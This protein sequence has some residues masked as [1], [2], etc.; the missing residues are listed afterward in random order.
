[1]RPYLVCLV[2]TL[3]A[4]L[5]CSAAA[6]NAA[7]TVQQNK[8]DSLLITE[9]PQV[10]EQW[11]LHCTINETPSIASQCWADAAAALTQ[12]TDR[13]RE[14]EVIQKVEELQA[15][16][17]ERAAQLQL[18]EVTPPETSIVSQRALLKSTALVRTSPLLRKAP[19]IAAK[20]A[21]PK[22]P[23]QTQAAS[24]KIRN[25]NPTKTTGTQKNK[26]AKKQPS[27]DV[28]NTAQS[29]KIKITAAAEQRA[30][31]HS[32]KERIRES[33]KGTTETPK[34]RKRLWRMPD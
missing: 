2:I 32:D 15:T 4:S 27:P 10:V 7:S 22:R 1:M 19:S 8:S 13:I 16:W 5:C 18:A 25:P 26:V 17:L 14:N 30:A 21:K 20:Q 33:E 12:Y 3:A 24:R 11:T 29:K 34:R 31:Q 23:P 9:L 28:L 6:Q